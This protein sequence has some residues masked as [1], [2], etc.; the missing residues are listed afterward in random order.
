MFEDEEDDGGSG[1]GNS[2]IEGEEVMGTE[3][4]TTPPPH[5]PPQAT[6][7]AMIIQQYFAH[8]HPVFDCRDLLLMVLG[9]LDI[10]H[11]SMYK[12]VNREFRRVIQL[13]HHPLPPSFMAHY[14]SSTSLLLW[15]MHEGGGSPDASTSAVAASLGNLDVLQYLLITAKPRCS[16][17]ASTLESAAAGGHLHV[18]EWI[19]EYLRAIP[20]QWY[21]HTSY[22]AARN[23]H[24]HVLQW[25]WDKQIQC[26][27]NDSAVAAAQG[28]HLHTIQ[29]L[30]AQVP[31]HYWSST[32][33]FYA[34][35]GNHLE[36]LKWLRSQDPPCPW[37]VS[38][39]SAAAGEGH[40][41]VL[42]WLRAQNPPCPWEAAICWAAAYD[43]GSVAVQEFLRDQQLPPPIS[44]NIEEHNNLE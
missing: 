5:L 43:G 25:L 12:L 33:C 8:L 10:N 2:G 41:E 24:T 37:G 44:T 38:T 9:Y 34:A 20:W 31:P 19:R 32:V 11:L 26:N 3:D 14:C 28:G 17:T 29:W 1:S 7:S 22:C 18:L 40:I 15:A 35:K 21:I 13:F 39:C 42:R 6:M 36:M 4:A 30:R 16:W 23:G 27:W